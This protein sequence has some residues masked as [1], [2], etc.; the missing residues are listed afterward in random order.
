MEPVAALAVLLGVLLVGSVSP[1][2]SFVLVARM[3]VARSRRDGVAAALGMG[4]GAVVFTTL[5]LLGLDGGAGV[6][7][8][9]LH[10]G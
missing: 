5:V 3:A 6:R 2:P 10:G 1:G 8:L 4:V 7:A 9:A